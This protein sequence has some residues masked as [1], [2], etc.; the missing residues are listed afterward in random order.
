MFQ[1]DFTSISLQY[2]DEEWQLTHEA[3]L[4]SKARYNLMQYLLPQD[5]TIWDQADYQDIIANEI[6][7]TLIISKDPMS[8]HNITKAIHYN[9]WL[10]PEALSE[11]E[12]RFCPHQH[13]ST[14]RCKALGASEGT[15]MRPICNST[16]ATT[17]SRCEQFHYNGPQLFSISNRGAR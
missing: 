12:S 4:A 1:I 10:H 14:R 2:P 5:E 3:I 6:K 15:K 7:F 9:M 8:W 11:L 17:A 16:N 13:I